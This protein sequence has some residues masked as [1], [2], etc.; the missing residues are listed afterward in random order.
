[1]IEVLFDIATQEVRATNKDEACFGLF[2]P[3]DGE[4]VIVI[5]AELPQFDYSELYLNDTQDGFFA[6]PEL[7][8]PDVTRAREILSNSPRGIPNKEIV[9][10][11]SIFAKRL[12]L[13]R[14][15]E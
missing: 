15:G 11:L 5:A 13:F 4:A 8:Q 6:I 12:G 10:L 2:K 7:E 1:M 9:E 3:N 14:K